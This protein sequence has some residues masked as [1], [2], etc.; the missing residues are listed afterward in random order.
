MLLH[1]KNVSPQH[2]NTFEKWFP[3]FPAFLND[4]L[5][6][7]PDFIVPVA[8]KGC[9]LLRACN[10][11][12]GVRID[13]SKLRYLRYFQLHDISLAKKRVAIVDDA[14]QYTST[15]QEYRQYFESRG[16]IVNTYSFVGHESLYQGRHEQYDEKAT[17]WKYLP[18]PVYQE[19]ILQQSSWLLS[20][21]E[22]FDLDHLVFESHLPADSFNQFCE[23]LRAN[24][25]LLF[26]DD[27]SH[28]GTARRFSLNDPLFHQR[29]PHL[30]DASIS[31]GQINKIK[32]SYNATTEELFFS[33]MIFPLWDTRRVGDPS[34]LIV[35]F[36][37]LLPFGIP[38][39]LD[40]K[41]KNSLSRIYY[42]IYLCAVVS[43]AKEFH[44]FA[45]VSLPFLSEWKLR[46]ND[47]DA[48]FGEESTDQFIESVTKYIR[49]PGLCRTHDKGAAY[50]PP[51][52]NRK[53]RFANFG[54]V[55]DLCRA[56][57][58]RKV[59]KKKSRMGIHFYLPYTSLFRQ[60]QDPILLSE[61]LDRYC[62]SGAVV[63]ETILQ[64]GTFMRVCR[65]GE[66]NSDAAFKRTQML[67]PIAIDQL[68]KELTL[69]HAE[70]EAMLLN[71]VL[72][73][74]V[75]D[76][77]PQVNQDLHC[78]LGTPNDFGSLV[79]VTHPNRAPT[80]PSIYAADRI[81]P[82]YRW[83][84]KKKLF[85]SSHGPQFIDDVQ[86]LFDDRQEVPYAEIVSYFKLLARI[87]LAY[88]QVDTLNILS[89]CREQ[90]YLYSHVLFNVRSA[91][92]SL[93][94]YAERPRKQD[95]HETG[96]HAESARSKLH[97]ARGVD[98]MIREIRSRFENDLDF[99]TP[100]RTLCSNYVPYTS[101][102]TRTIELLY[103]ITA[104]Q[105][106]FANIA[107]A[108][109]TGSDR[110]WKECATILKVAPKPRTGWFPCNL[111]EL[112]A[113]QGRAMKMLCDLRDQVLALVD[114]L[115]RE[116]PI[117]STRIQIDEK[118]RARN[119]ATHHAYKHD[120]RQLVLLYLDYSGLRTI[121]EPKEDIIGQ[122]YRIVEDAR[123]ARNGVKLYGGRGGDDAFTILFRDPKAA[124]SCAKD[125]KTAFTE[126]LF[127]MGSRGDVKFGLAFRLLPEKG[128][129]PGI[130]E[131]WGDSKD[132]CE[133][134]SSDFRNR[135]NLL[136]SDASYT[137]L[138]GTEHVDCLT[139]FRE[140]MDG[141]G[142]GVKKVYM[143]TDIEAIQQ[144]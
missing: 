144:K 133:F 30:Q 53:A 56:S 113:D 5:G 85:C 6:W 65:S 115:P 132:C 143:A 109:D 60:F 1:S 119:I 19:Y 15:L 93:A 140:L 124:I 7:K 42:D 3:R 142:T 105:R 46:R 128:K 36:P 102:F 48:L 96:K 141:R 111:L 29:I 98:S 55:I 99:M 50:T 67:I 107:L 44:D 83:D 131:C 118:R 90:N 25:L 22:H 112:R 38:R 59:K 87:Y 79:H 88:R 121:P 117:L 61:S 43:L 106:L 62:D 80:R 71:K 86:A 78:L 21:G 12:S 120:L 52:E 18:G 4:L 76:Y 127:M 89:I 41:D 14:T 9:K 138:V 108:L 39:T 114:N 57:Y 17:V 69:P 35:D 34:S 26:L 91:Y 70:V 139:T 54:D 68:R 116:E 49:S 82:H 11:V 81:S 74:F 66:P 100:L 45:A 92:S 135:G 16:A 47:L 123:T 10:R 31:F 136:L 27:H 23:V 8:K 24:G 103:E 75:F 64:D 125:I 73:N 28:T 20:N 130:L 126:S 104:L 110:Y 129:E 77:P 137:A 95:A 37:V 63:A 134:K 94:N 51:K 2:L 33:P 84:K 32:F 97:G 58:E 13:S 40:K 101:E 122:Y 72:A